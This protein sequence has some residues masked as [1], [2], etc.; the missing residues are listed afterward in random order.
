MK[1]VNTGTIYF[2]GLCVV[3]A[4]EINHYRR[5]P[6]AESFKFEDI[7][8]VDF[9]PAAHGLDPQQVHK[10]M[11]VRDKFGEL[12]TGVD[13]FRVIWQDLPRY[14]FLA[15]LSTRPVVRW[16]LDLG[17]NVFVKIRPYL[18]RR[19]QD[20]SASPYCEVSK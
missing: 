16:G 14:H 20:C 8:A 12:H 2:D 17:Y 6:G 11:H 10:V 13:A 9:D 18:P 4:S 5:L 15:R 1:A 3:C 19:K 7:T